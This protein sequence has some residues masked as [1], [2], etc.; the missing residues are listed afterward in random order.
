M[1]LMAFI[2]IHTF[3]LIALTLLMPMGLHYFNDNMF[4]TSGVG[5]TNGVAEFMV[6]GR[7]S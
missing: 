2:L 6:K 7:V 4:S 3:I 1:R 5:I